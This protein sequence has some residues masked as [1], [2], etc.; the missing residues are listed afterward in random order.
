MSYFRRKIDLEMTCSKVPE[1]SL[2]VS[3]LWRHLDESLEG[4]PY[5]WGLISSFAVTD[6]ICLAHSGKAD[7]VP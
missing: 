1:F 5:G 7:V 4:L 6:R 3:D 2:S